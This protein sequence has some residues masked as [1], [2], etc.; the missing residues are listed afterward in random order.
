MSSRE[1]KGKWKNNGFVCIGTLEYFSLLD[2]L[3]H[4][5][6]L[7]EKHSRKQEV[8]EQFAILSANIVFFKDLTRG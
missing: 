2:Q 1:F 7:R 5:F 8:C 3:I 6:Y 4:T